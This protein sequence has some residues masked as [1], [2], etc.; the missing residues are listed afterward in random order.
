MNAM[1]SLIEQM[2]EST[3]VIGLGDTVS[4]SVWASLLEFIRMKRSILQ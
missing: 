4:R 1:Q 3:S 2:D